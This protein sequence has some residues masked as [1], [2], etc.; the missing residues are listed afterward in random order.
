MDGFVK[1]N[2]WNYTQTL[3]D[4]NRKP[5]ISQREKENLTKLYSHLPSD[6]QDAI[7]DST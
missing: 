2:H 1:M 6:L 3:W 7:G 5:T 4:L